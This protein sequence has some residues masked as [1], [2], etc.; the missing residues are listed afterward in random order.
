MDGPGDGQD[1]LIAPCKCSG[2]VKC[3]HLGCL[4]RWI[5]CRLGVD[6]KAN[7]P[8]RVGLLACEMCKSPYPTTVSTG[9][10]Q[11]PLVEVP[12]MKA[13]YIVLEDRTRAILHVVP[14]DE[15]GVIRLGRSGCDVN[16]A[17]VSLS[18][19][20]A[21][22]TLEEGKLVLRDAG[23]RF[24]TAVCLKRP[25]TLEKGVPVSLQ[26]GRTLLRLSM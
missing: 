6:D 10:R 4:R 17:E 15:K 21:T 11:V 2:S 8:Y 19:A 20:H 24:G 5:S 13:P 14:F 22:I 1:P 12:R 7:G 16:I 9:S 23:S 26:V 18:R 3:V 25:L